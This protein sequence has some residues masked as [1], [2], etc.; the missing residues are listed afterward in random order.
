MQI[1]HLRLF[2]KAA[3][4]GSI[5][6]A[7][8][9]SHISQSA[10]SQQIQRLEQELGAELL[11][12]SNKGVVLT[13]AG[14]IVEK[15]AERFII[16]QDN[17]LADLSTMLSQPA[18]RTTL[19]VAASPVVGVYGLPCTMFR[20]KTAFPDVTFN[21][22]TRPSRDAENEVLQGESD[23]GFIIGPPQ[24]KDLVHKR[25]YSDPVC[26]VAAEAYPVERQMTMDGLQAFP[27]VVHSVRSSLYG[28]IAEYFER[29]GRSFSRYNVLFHLDT[30]ESVKSSVLQSH[31]LAFLPYLAI[32][33][34]L[35]LKQLKR[36]ELENFDLNYDVHIIYRQKKRTE[37]L[38][39]RIAEYFS[40]LGSDAF[41]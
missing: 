21:L 18:S 38:P 27:L 5:S 1:E 13:E 3:T 39:Y 32:K 23:I 6:N 12:R 37:D 28:L 22:T 30:A 20:V 36:I 31:G 8:E 25:V 16:L 35:Y 9:V 17:M 2:H 11:W 40:Q 29:I 26:L 19:H 10:L 24:G 15:Y 41:C 33:K 34:E 14:T 7:A 4:L